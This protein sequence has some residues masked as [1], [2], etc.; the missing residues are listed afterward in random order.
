M[1]AAH[2]GSHCLKKL[3]CVSCASIVINDIFAP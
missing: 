2:Y 3:N 1:R